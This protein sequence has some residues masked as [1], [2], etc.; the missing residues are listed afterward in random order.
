VRGNVTGGVVMAK[1]WH[2]YMTNFYRSHPAPADSF[3][4][5]KTPFMQQ[6]SSSVNNSVVNDV[7]QYEGGLKNPPLPEPSDSTQP[8]Q[9]SSDGNVPAEQPMGGS[10][11]A[12]GAAS[13]NAAPPR[14]QD[15][16]GH[17]I[18]DYDWSTDQQPPSEERGEQP[19]ESDR[20][21]P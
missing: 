21:A 17:Y 16:R 11:D 2:D 13:P 9:G 8:D 12:S 20:N 4:P 18:H 1:I 14:V 3:I 15:N 7:E 10:P 5:P 19:G 6:P